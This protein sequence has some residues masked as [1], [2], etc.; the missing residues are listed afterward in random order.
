MT[1]QELSS[2]SE[3]EQQM[4]QNSSLLKTT[5]APPACAPSGDLWIVLIEWHDKEWVAIESISVS[6]I[7]LTKQDAVEE[8]N[9]IE[10]NYKQ[11]LAYPIPIGFSV[12]ARSAPA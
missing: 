6:N 5:A 3:L 1:T 12:K 9:R 7:Y 8:A 11:A 4:A 2:L 10:R